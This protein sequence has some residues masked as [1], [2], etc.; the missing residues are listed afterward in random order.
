M[1]EETEIKPLKSKTDNS[2]NDS[3]KKKRKFKMPSALIIILGIIVIVTILTWGFQGQSYNYYDQNGNPVA[4]TVTAVGLFSIPVYIIEGFANAAGIIFYLFVLGWFLDVVIGSGAMESGIKSLISGLHGKEIIL[5][6]IMFFLFA[7]GGT[8]YGMQEETL[9]FYLIIIPMFLLAGFDTV[10]GLLVILLGTT[11][12][13]ASSVINPFSIG[14]AVDS[15]NNVNIII[16]GQT[17]NITMGDGMIARLIMF[18]ILT[19]VGCIFM[20][21]YAMRIKAKPEK[22]LTYKTHNNDVEWAKETFKTSTAENKK[23]NGRQ[24]WILSIF[25]I[26]FL[27]MFLGMFPWYTFFNDGIPRNNIDNDGWNSWLIGGMS[28]FGAW[29]FPELILL[30]TASTIVIS[31]IAKMRGSQIMESFWR[32]SKDMLSVAIIIAVA[33]AIPGILAA[34]GLDYYIAQGIGGAISN[35]GAWGWSYTMFIVFFIFGLLIPSTSGLAAATM[36]TFSIIAS[37]IASFNTSPEQFTQIL[38]VTTCVY[39]LAVGMINMFIPTQAVVMLSCEK[40]RVPYGTALKP[41]GIYLGIQLVV[42]LAIIIPLLQIVA[43]NY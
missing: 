43:N 13:F 5:V 6:P 8:T 17:I 31:L 42:T 12:G 16:D 34:S 3:G 40:A 35:V 38:I 39:A 15:I 24:K 1:S 25:G 20:T 26:T 27:I 21:L 4:S 9:A 22:S 30:F 18:I 11:T 14:V 36:G 19:T 10:T 32:G 2:V 37:Q 23:M 29:D 41:I 7:L 33:R 28:T